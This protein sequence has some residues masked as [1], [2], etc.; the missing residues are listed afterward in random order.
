MNWLNFK[1]MLFSYC[2]YNYK[3]SEGFRRFSNCVPSYQ[4]NRPCNLVLTCLNRFEAGKNVDKTGIVQV[5]SGEYLVISYN[6]NAIRYMVSFG[7]E[8]NMPYCTC[9]SWKKACKHIFAVFLKF[10]KWSWDALFLLYVNFPFFQLDIYS[11]EK[12]C[13]AAEDITWAIQSWKYWKRRK[14]FW[15]STAKRRKA[16]GWKRR[17]WRN[18]LVDLPPTESWN[19]SLPSHCRSLLHKIKNLFFVEDNHET[20]NELHETLLNLRKKFKS[21]ARKENCIILEPTGTNSNLKRKIPNMS[22]YNLPETERR[23]KP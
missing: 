6:D 12:E 17:T 5:R 19:L 9:A 8:K 10:Q 23:K 13:S 21:V 7:N 16:T 11:K 3:Y 2:D 15:W 18:N 22:L 1:Y 14:S 4:K 20:I